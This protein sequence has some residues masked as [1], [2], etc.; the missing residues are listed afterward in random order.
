MSYTLERTFTYE[1]LQSE[2]YRCYVTIDRNMELSNV[3][4]SISIEPINQI[5]NN[6]KKTFGDR[7]I[8][9]DYPYVDSD[10]T[11]FIIVVIKE[12]DKDDFFTY[13]KTLGFRKV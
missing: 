1:G 6:I 13:L 10:V 7:I 4:L 3:T 11:N 9:W 2:R 8:L 5:I 12:Q